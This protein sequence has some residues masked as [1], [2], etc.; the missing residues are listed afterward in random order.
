MRIRNYF[1]SLEDQFCQ[2]KLHFN[3]L[4]RN[5]SNLLMTVFHRQ[6]GISQSITDIVPSLLFRRIHRE[7]TGH[8][9]EMNVGKLKKNDNPKFRVH[10][11]CI[12]INSLNCE[13]YMDRWI[14]MHG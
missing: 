4:T 8:G 3:F 5:C 9:V 7:L 14:K 1:S 2:G 13:A 11:Y 10:R 6:F 12:G